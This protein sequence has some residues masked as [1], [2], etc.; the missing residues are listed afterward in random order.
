MH[1]YLC[2]S[3][4]FVQFQTSS[5]LQWLGHSVSATSSKQAAH[6]KKCFQR[7]PDLQ[8][9]QQ[10]LERWATVCHKCF[11]GCSRSSSYQ[12]HQKFRNCELTIF[13]LQHVL[14]QLTA[15]GTWGAASSQVHVLWHL[16]GHEFEPLHWRWFLRTCLV[17]WEEFGS[18]ALRTFFSDFLFVLVS[19]L[20]R[21]SFYIVF[22][23]L[24]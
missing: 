4:L 7:R 10:C 16:M 13:H 24:F 17:Q 21:F 1:W 6:R 3:I 12:K 20:F 2:S 11:L 22:Q 15:I 19:D 8:A 9:Q 18:R 5:H 14:G 23:N